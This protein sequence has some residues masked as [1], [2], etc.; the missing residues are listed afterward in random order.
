M[1]QLKSVKFTF[2]AMC[3]RSFAARASANSI[4]LF[5]QSGTL[6]PRLTGFAPGRAK[7][8]AGAR[9]PAFRL[10]RIS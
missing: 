4:R 5:N 9:F 8:K 3:S 1:P 6:S 2:F 10:H 7:Q